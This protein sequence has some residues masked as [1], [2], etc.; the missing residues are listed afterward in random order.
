MKKYFFIGI[1]SLSILFASCL[2]DKNVDERVYGMRGV[3]EG[4]IIELAVDG[5][6]ILYAL[7]FKDED[8]MVDVLEVRLAADQVASEDI[9]VELSLDNS[10]AILADYDAAN[11]TSLTQ[12]PLDFYILPDG[13]TI[14]IPAGRRSVLVKLGLNTSKFD[15]SAIY[16]LG[17]RIKSVNQTGYTIS[18]NFGEAIVAFAAK[19]KYD[20]AYRLRGFHNRPGLEAPYDEEVHM[21]TSG[22]NS[23]YMYWPALGDAAH[24][25]NGGVTY[26]GDF[27]TNFY[28]D[29]STEA[30]TRWDFSPYAT[31]LPTAIGPATDSRYDPV[32]KIIYAQYYYNNNPTERG[33]TDTLTY[34]G[35]R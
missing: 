15:A 27:T 14:T 5:H 18:G 11:G 16:A 21:I 9:A 8:I 22:A 12:F 35:P 33:F 30:I 10:L 1:A 23:V 6:Y 19:N 20:G 26:Y 2:K 31:T 28:F 3:D 17:F 32:N 13:L 4:K 7:D 29:P 34:L 24:P 25:L